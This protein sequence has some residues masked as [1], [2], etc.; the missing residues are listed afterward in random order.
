MESVE[1][2]RS[3]AFTRV[4]RRLAREKTAAM[5]LELVGLGAVLWVALWVGAA[6]VGMDV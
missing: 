3:R 2:L 1:T 5:A 4:R 6:I